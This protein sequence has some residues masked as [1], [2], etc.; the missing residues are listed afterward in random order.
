MYKYIIFAAVYLFMT[1]CVF[2]SAYCDFPIFKSKVLRYTFLVI[3]SL[4][5]PFLLVLTLLCAIYVGLDEFIKLI[6]REYNKIKDDL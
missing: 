4:L 2:L 3:F 1:V 6:K 5:W